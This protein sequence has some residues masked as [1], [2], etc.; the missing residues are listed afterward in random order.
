MKCAASDKEIITADCDSHIAF[1]RIHPFADRNGR[2]GR[3]IMNYFL[4]K[5]DIPPLV[6]EKDD[7][8]RYFH[9]LANEDVKEFSSYACER[10]QK[11]QRRMKSFVSK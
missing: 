1:E 4:M 8:E 2:I 7:K 5:K 3:L 6:I 9:V 10:I 11:E